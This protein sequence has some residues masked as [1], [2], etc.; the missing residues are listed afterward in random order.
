MACGLVRR[1]CA[2]SCTCCV[3]YVT[4]VRVV[5]AGGASEAG[6]LYEKMLLR[7]SPK[8]AE[9]DIV[10]P[11]DD[12]FEEPDIH[13]YDAITWTGSSLCAHSGEHTSNKQIEFARKVLYGGPP[14]F[15]SCWAVQVAAVASGGVCATNPRGR[16]MGLARKVHTPPAQFRGRLVVWG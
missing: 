15:G 8:E 3:R 10:Y 11:A 14:G 16:E 13:D 9:C 6:V 1:C 7:W 4:M 5:C 2:L 12:D